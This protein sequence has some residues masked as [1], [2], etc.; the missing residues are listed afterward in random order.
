METNVSGHLQV[1]TNKN[2]IDSTCVVKLKQMCIVDFYPVMTTTSQS[3]TTAPKSTS[4]AGTTQATTSVA[5]ATTAAAVSTIASTV[6]VMSTASPG[7][8]AGLSYYYCLT[9]M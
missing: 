1:Y 3:T 2:L 8:T 5:L 6:A 9:G 7:T 4:A